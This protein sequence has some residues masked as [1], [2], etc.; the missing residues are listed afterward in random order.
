[1]ARSKNQNRMYR[2][3]EAVTIKKKTRVVDKKREHEG[4]AE[5]ELRPIDQDI[6]GESGNV[7]ADAYFN[8]ERGEQMIPIRL[9][10]EAMVSIPETRLERVDTSGAVRQDGGGQSS[11]SPVSPETVQFWEKHFADQARLKELEKKEK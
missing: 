4:K 1:M 8:E 10:N 2:F 9:P 6:T 5:G 11:P 3:G 7:C